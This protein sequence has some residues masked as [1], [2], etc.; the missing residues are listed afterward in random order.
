MAEVSNQLDGTTVYRRL[1]RYV[2]PYW[3]MFALAAVGMI[4]F[5]GTEAAFA[6]I[7]QPLF[8]DGFVKKDP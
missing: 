6:R 3:K 4:I 7:I 5:A 2:K 8:D 1:L